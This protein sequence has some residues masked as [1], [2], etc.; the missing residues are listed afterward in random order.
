MCYRRASLLRVLLFAPAILG[1]QD[2][3]REPLRSSGAAA[4]VE[5]PRALRP[6]R[7]LC[8]FLGSPDGSWLWYPRLP[9]PDA[10][11]RNPIS[12]ENSKEG[13]EIAVRQASVRR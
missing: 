11:G 2:P 1:A 7:H 13:T 4:Q 5:L 12:P 9:T 6:L 10:C 8:P 3:G